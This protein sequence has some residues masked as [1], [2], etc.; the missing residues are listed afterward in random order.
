M[1]KRLGVKILF[2]II[3][4]LLFTLIYIGGVVVINSEVKKSF[5]NVSE[6]EINGLKAMDAMKLNIVQ[7]QQWLTDASATAY[8]DGYDEA[9][10]AR[11]HVYENAKL[12]EEY[13]PEKK[14]FL[15]KMLIDFEAYYETGVRMADAYINEGRDAGNVVMED[16]DQTASKLTEELDEIE[17]YIDSKVDEAINNNSVLINIISVES[18]IMIVIFIVDFIGTIFYVEKTIIKPIKNVTGFIK[19]ISER[20]LTVSEINNKRNDEIGILTDSANTLLNN[21]KNIVGNLNESA[22][23]LSSSC[24]TMNDSAK[25]IT[26]ALNDTTITIGNITTATNEQAEKNQISNDNVLE[27]K[28]LADQNMQVTN[29]LFKLNQ[30]IQTVS[31]ESVES[32]HKLNEVTHENQESLVEILNSLNSITESTEKIDNISKLIEGIATQTN[33]LSLNASIEAARAGEVGRGFAVVAEEVRGLAEETANSVKEINE[34]I[35][36]LQASVNLANELGHKVSQISE[37]EGEQLQ[38]TLSK[39]DEI[40]SGLKSIDSEITKITESST[41]MAE[42]CNVVLDA[43]N[44]MSA[45]AEENASSTEE[46]YASTEEVLASMNNVSQISDDIYNESQKQMGIVGEFKMSY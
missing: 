37:K 25:E 24:M 17:S 21:L 3:L 10:D 45:I 36:E 11:E 20:D 19:T 8:T 38:I 14:D 29:E 9:A 23:M 22:S 30:N 26:N 4:M 43:V 35:G 28:E 18:I 33:L 46:C 41:M 44:S 15:E 34:M 2:P 16:F 7:V 12:L 6:V 40:S 39:F 32:I 5:G 42:N 13:Y 1:S 31:D 27:L